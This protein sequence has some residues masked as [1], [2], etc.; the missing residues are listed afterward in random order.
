DIEFRFIRPRRFHQALSIFDDLNI[1][2]LSR[3]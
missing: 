2:P 1:R 3:E